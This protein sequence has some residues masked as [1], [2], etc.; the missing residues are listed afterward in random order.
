MWQ[1]PV[2]LLRVCFLLSQ[3]SAVLTD[4]VIFIV[5]LFRHR[6]VRVKKK[7]KIIEKIKLRRRTTIDRVPNERKI[8]Y[9]FIVNVRK[10]DFN[11]C[12]QSYLT[13]FYTGFELGSLGAIT[14]NPIV[15]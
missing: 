8:V 1:I 12:L 4:I 5:I 9:V 14:V 10:H 6:I 3:C 15:P 2:Q 11:Y 7:E 13:M